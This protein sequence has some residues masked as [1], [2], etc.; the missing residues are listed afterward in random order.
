[1]DNLTAS[2]ILIVI[3]LIIVVF[4]LLKQKAGAEKTIHK[5]SQQFTLVLHNKKAVERCKRIHDKYPELCAGIDFSL[6]ENGDEGEIEQW[7]S[8]KPKPD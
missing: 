3:V 7:N 2:A 6:R 8:D 5:M 1:M 4:V